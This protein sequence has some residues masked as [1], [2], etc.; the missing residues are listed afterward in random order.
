MHKINSTA[1][2]HQM[3][4]NKIISTSHDN[5]FKSKE[6]LREFIGATQNNILVSKKEAQAN[7][8]KAIDDY[9]I[10]RQTREDK[11]YADM[12]NANARLL[13]ATKE[14]QTQVQSQEKVAKDKID[15]L[16][17]NGQ[18]ATLSPEQ[19]VDYEQKA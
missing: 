3:A 15:M 9:K 1:F 2:D 17:K 10:Q 14:I 12:N 8:Q 13:T 16:V 6:R 18:W 19:K 4:I 5:E 11:L 7:I